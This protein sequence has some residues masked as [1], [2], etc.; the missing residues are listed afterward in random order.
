MDTGARHNFTS[1][2]NVQTIALWLAKSAEVQCGYSCQE[3]N[4]GKKWSLILIKAAQ[5]GAD[6]RTSYR[7]P[8]QLTLRF[9]GY[10]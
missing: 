3:S 9:Q 1:T 10:G 6:S 8:P 5:T 2:I 7:R 4:H